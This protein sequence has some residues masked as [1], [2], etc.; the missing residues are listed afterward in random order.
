M[1]TYIAN[2]TYPVV[3]LAWNYGEYNINST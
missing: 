2:W 3:E 1:S